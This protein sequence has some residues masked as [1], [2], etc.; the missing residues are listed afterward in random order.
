M[1]EKCTSVVRIYL[2]SKIFF[3]AENSERPLNR[4]GEFRKFPENQGGGERES[5]S[6]RVFIVR[7][8]RREA[9]IIQYNSGMKKVSFCGLERLLHVVGSSYRWLQDFLND[10]RDERYYTVLS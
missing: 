5:S 1:Y 8:S 6:C 9:G 7:A 4:R 10:I 3:L 2:V